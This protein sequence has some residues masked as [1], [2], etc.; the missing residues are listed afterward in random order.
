MNF[1]QTWNILEPWNLSI[2]FPVPNGKRVTSVA[3]IAVIVEGVVAVGVIG[4]VGGVDL[5]R[6]CSDR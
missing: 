3:A 4:P 6:L 1:Q 2:S 5:L